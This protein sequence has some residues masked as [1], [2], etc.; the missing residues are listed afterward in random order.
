MKRSVFVL[1]LAMSTGLL[2]TSCFMIDFDF[3]NGTDPLTSDYE[4]VFMTRTELESSVKVQTAQ[5]LGSPGKIYYRSPYIFVNERYK[6]I[7]IIDNTDPT[8]PQNVR[9]VAI[10]GNVDMAVK[11]NTLFVDNAVDLVTLDISNVD[12]IKVV[13]RI[14]GTFPAYSF[15]PDGVRFYPENDK[16]IVGWKKK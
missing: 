8:N 10:A 6:G 4:P 5:A 14:Q 13:T 15:S 1:C 16:I 9:F 11:G 12:D 7:H 2:A 3:I